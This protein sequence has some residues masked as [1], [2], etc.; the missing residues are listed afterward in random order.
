MSDLLK[1]LN[2]LR[3][4]A[5]A[6]FRHDLV[7]KR[8]RDG[9]HLALQE[10][11]PDGRKHHKPTRQQ[12]VEQKQAEETRLILR[13]LGELLDAMPGSRKTLRHLRVVEKA[14][15]REG[16]RVLHA[17]PLDVLQHALEQLEGLVSNWSPVGLANLRSKMA[18]AIIDREHMAPENENPAYRTAAVLETPSELS[19]DCAALPEVLDGGDDAALA[20]AY[21]ALGDLAPAAPATDLTAPQMQELGSASA[22]AL[23][24]EQARAAR[25]V[26]PPGELSLRELQG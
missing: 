11:R 1:F 24:P 14:L 26:P 16:L 21:A 15:H 22:R 7:I 13:Q 12:L 20:A 2:P 8:E 3:H 18:V 23:A 9:L 25:S 10:P 5:V 19:L 6:F 17:V 4:A